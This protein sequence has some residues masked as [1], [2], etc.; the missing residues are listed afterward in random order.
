MRPA[1]FAI[2]L[3]I[4]FLL[5][6]PCPDTFAAPAHSDTSEIAELHT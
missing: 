6:Q 2:V 5:T 4:L 1:I 3:C